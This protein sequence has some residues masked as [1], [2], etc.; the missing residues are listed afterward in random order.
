MTATA[1]RIRCAVAVTG[2]LVVVAEAQ[3]Q[4]TVSGSPST[5]KISAATAG[6][7]PL[8]V[9][10]A[11]TKYTVQQPTSG[12][13]TVTANINAPMPAGVTLTIALATS[14]GASSGTVTL[15]TTPQNV[16]T[17][18][19]T[20]VTNRA[21]TYTLNATASAGVVPIQTRS[22]TLTLINTP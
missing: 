11:G 21:I 18:I 12:H 10:R 19:A 2:L 3:A 4:I 16:V 7:A 8:A 13:Y 6:S 5:M 9:T 20:K 17:G 14:S 15:G 1:R 22:V